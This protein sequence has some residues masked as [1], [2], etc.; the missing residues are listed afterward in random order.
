MWLMWV[1]WAVA[2]MGLVVV[3]DSGVATVGLR[4]LG[5]FKKIYIYI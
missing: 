5:Y 3:G 2:D 4:L 1:C